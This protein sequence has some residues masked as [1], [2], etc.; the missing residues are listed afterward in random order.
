M[1]DLFNNTFEPLPASNFH[2]NDGIPVRYHICNDQTENNEKRA[3]ERMP[4]ELWTIILKKAGAGGWRVTTEN[5][6][7]NYTR[8]AREWQVLYKTC[9]SMWSELEINGNLAG[10]FARS[11]EAPLNVNLNWQVHREH[12]Q[13]VY[14]L[15]DGRDIQVESDNGFF[16]EGY[17]HHAGFFVPNVA[18]IDPLQFQGARSTGLVLLLAQGCQ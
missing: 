10:S 12:I 8:T 3:I 11:R 5:A 18:A 6:I 9:T 2:H 4:Q 16:T 7:T 15:D 13:G 1:A 14:I 17:G